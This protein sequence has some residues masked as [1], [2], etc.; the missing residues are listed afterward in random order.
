MKKIIAVC[1]FEKTCDKNINGYVKFSEDSGYT[2]I[3]VKLSGVKPGYHGFHIHEAGDI[4]D[5]CNGACKHYNPFGV[6]H[7]GQNSIVRHVGDLGNI[8]ADRKGDVRMTFH[9]HL[10]KLSGPCSI[11]G[12]SVVIHEDPDDE[13]LG[14]LDKNGN[15]IDQRKHDESLKTG[16]A[17]KRIACGVI[18]YHRRMFS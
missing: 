12:R 15:V 7:G 3:K 5:N 4:R 14:G 10:V 9:D 8:L 11:I 6:S 16:N 1:N 13:G 2:K 17:G 18:G